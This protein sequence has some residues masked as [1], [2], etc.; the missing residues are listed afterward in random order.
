MLIKRLFIAGI[1]L[2]GA[3]AVFAQDYFDFGKVP[4][5]PDKA[6]VQVDLSPMVLGIAGEAARSSNPAAADLL[7]GIKGVRVRVYKTVEDADAV[8]KYVDKL[9]GQ[10]EK[11]DWQQVVRVEDGQQV[12]IYIKGDG[13]TVTGV[14][15]MVVGAGDAVFINVAGSITPQQV[16]SLVSKLGAG[17]TLVSLGGLDLGSRPA[18]KPDTAQ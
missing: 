10:L 13:N 16:A 2:A 9:S 7:A 11:A 18:E 15:G 12:R 1:A 5:V 3:T 6:S 14:T 17:G 4:G 8:V